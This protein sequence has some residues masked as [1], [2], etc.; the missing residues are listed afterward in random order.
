MTLH[1]LAR[2]VLTASILVAATAATAGAYV[3]GDFGGRC[4]R[5]PGGNP[6][7]RSQLG[8]PANGPLIN[9]TFSWDQNAIAAANDWSTVGASFRFRVETGGTAIDPCAPS[10]LCSG[11]ASGNPVFFS[12]GICGR[13]FDEDIIAA[14]VNCITSNGSIV[15]SAVFVHNDE[16]WNAYDG[17]IFRDGSGQFVNDLRRVLLHEFGHVLGLEHPDD[18]GQ[19]VTAIMNARLSNLDRLQSDDI[20]GLLSIYP[21][22]TA[23]P[24]T[25]EGCHLSP[26]PSPSLLPLLT[27]AAAAFML[28]VRRRR[29]PAGAVAGVRRRR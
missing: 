11:P 3:C 19:S 14:T 20:M 10:G 6:T 13:P 4:V 17:P 16:L 15:S 26:H 9:G 22:A 8:F 23:P 21:V 12:S 25:N 24:G 5:W 18:F 2:Q 7:L 1:R 29:P 27:V 28:A